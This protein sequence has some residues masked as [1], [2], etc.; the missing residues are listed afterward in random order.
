MYFRAG[1]LRHIVRYHIYTI[2]YL[3][4]YIEF[5]IETGQFRTETLYRT[6]RMKENTLFPTYMQTTK[7]IKTYTNNFREG[8]SSVADGISAG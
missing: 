5:Y 1:I 8:F 2:N 7:A 3:S 6:Y 4:F